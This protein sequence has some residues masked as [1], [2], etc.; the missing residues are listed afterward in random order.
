MSDGNQ[1]G[2]LVFC[3]VGLLGG[4]GIGFKMSHSLRIKKH[5]VQIANLEQQIAEREAVLALQQP[6]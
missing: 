2:R 6:H 4:A 1:V 3:L 5:K